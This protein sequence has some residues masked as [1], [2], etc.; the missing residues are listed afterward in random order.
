MAIVFSEGIFL[1]ADLLT[2][3]TGAGT[4]DGITTDQIGW[5]EDQN[6]WYYCTAAAAGSST[7][8]ALATGGASELGTA[9]ENTGAT[10]PALMDATFTWQIAQTQNLTF[11]NATSNNNLL[12]VAPASGADT[13][14][15]GWGFSTGGGDTV[16]V[17]SQTFDVNSTGITLNYATWPAAD[18]TAS[19]VLTTDGAGA[20]S[21]AAAGGNTS[22]LAQ[23][24][25]TQS[26][27]SLSASGG[28]IDIN[29][30]SVLDKGLVISLEVTRTAGTGGDDID[31]EFFT[32]DTF[33]AADRIYFAEA[34]DGTT[35]FIDRSGFFVED[36][37]VTREFHVRVTNQSASAATFDVQICAQGEGLVGAVDHLSFTDLK[38]TSYTAVSW[39]H[40]KYDP[41]TPTVTVS[42]PAS[43][44]T[45]DQ[46]GVKNCTTDTTS[47]TISGNGNNVEDPSS[48]GSTAAS[49][50]IAA[51]GVSL[52][53]QYDGTE[54]WIV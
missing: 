29:F 19:Q 38:T 15:L 52:I 4:N 6:N 49:V 31:I 9:V 40:V 47:C 11:E 42:F 10:N 13:V 45:D 43:P 8:A 18:G 22:S 28:S 25:V 50:G 54:W 27:G 26:T 34:A 46:V 20:L 53:Y 14:T 2:D 30:T 32:K 35:A 33:L 12:V 41:S 17:N 5:A 51:A 44:A 21:W 3:L 16:F 48:P 7:W 36:E 24:D 37:D 39:E 23:V 1:W